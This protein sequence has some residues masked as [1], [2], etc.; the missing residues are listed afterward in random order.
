M[1]RVT[2]AEAKY[3]H[4]RVPRACIKITNRGGR[5]KNYYIEESRDVM[6]LMRTIR[7]DIHKPIDELPVLGV[8]YWNNKNYHRGDTNTQADK[9]PRQQVEDKPYRRDTRPRK[10]R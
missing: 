9:K 5:H 7:E 2:Q 6:F 8:R 1:I 3:L 4:R 10:R